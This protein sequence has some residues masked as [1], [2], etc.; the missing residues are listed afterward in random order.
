MMKKALLIVNPS[1]GGEKAPEYADVAQ[2]KLESLFDVVEIK[3]TEKGGDATRFAKEASELG[4]HSVFVM[5]GDGTVNEGLSGLVRDEN[6]TA[7]G[8]F[9]LG[10]VNDLARA[11]NLPLDP[12]EAIEAL[13]IDATQDID[14]G[15]INDQY[16]MNVVGIGTIPEAINDV[17]VE[18]KT[19]MGK[20][21]YFVSGFKHVL[22]NKSYEFK[23]IADGVEHHI[24][25][26]TLLIGLTNSIGGFETLLPDAKVDDGFLHMVY[27]KDQSLLDTVKAIPELLKGVNQDSDN[28]GYLQI[29]EAS[30]ESL[31]DEI[32]TTNIDG[33]EGPKL[34]IHVKVLENRV[35]VYRGKKDSD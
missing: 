20:L 24:H 27:I 34:P 17:A 22:S 21:A 8:F 35:K 9:P 19:K 26:S 13:D 7:F 15:Q 4:Y 14:L 11:L 23:V 33:D 32:L 5:G 1:A 25:T 2:K 28:V 10:T 12:H 30:I 31:S 16:F 18:D 29:K 3:E 6:T